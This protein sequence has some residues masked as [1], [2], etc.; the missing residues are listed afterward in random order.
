MKGFWTLRDMEG[1]VGM[2]GRWAF[3]YNLSMKIKKT[4]IYIPRILDCPC[5]ATHQHTLSAD[6]KFQQHTSSLSTS[7]ETEL[8]F[9]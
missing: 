3:L 4:G 7:R 9:L 5:F 6:Q 1:Y 8:L 2:M